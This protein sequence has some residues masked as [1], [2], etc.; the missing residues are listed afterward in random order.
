MDRRA[1]LHSY[2][3]N[4]DPEG[5]YLEKAV[6]LTLII[7]FFVLTFYND[8]WLLDLGKELL[9]SIILTLGFLAVLKSYAEKNDPILAFTNVFFAHLFTAYS[10]LFH[11]N[12][13]LQELF[14]YMSGH[15]VAIVIGLWSLFQLKKREK[16][17]FH[18]GGYLGHSYEHPTQAILF[19][20]TTIIMM[21][22]PITPSFIGE[23]LI[24]GHIH[25]HQVYL[26]LISS[27]NFVF[28]GFA[29]IRIYSL[30]FLG[31]HIKSYHE[32]PNQYS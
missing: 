13:N 30:L 18:L 15:L 22:F 16:E 9:M 23:D 6:F 28:T 10:A 27:L 31:P 7:S 26:A 4:L 14:I 3:Y 20:I 19:F 2:N 21:G 12:F 29:L 1:F 11:D 25:H 32:A 17:Y 24:F 5:I 8:D